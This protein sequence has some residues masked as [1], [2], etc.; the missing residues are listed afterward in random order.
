VALHKVGGLAISDSVYQRG[1]RYLLKTQRD[2]GSWHVT[3]RSRP[4]QTYY[5]SGFP[6]GADQFISCAASGWATWALVLACEEK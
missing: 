1:L 5:E 4:F 3:S 2:D 6:H